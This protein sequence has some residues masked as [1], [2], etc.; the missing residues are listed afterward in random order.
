MESQEETFQHP[1]GIVNFALHSR[2]IHHVGIEND[3]HYQLFACRLISALWVIIAMSESPTGSPWNKKLR[4]LLPLAMLGVA[5]TILWVTYESHQRQKNNQQAKL[6]QHG[7]EELAAARAMVDTHDPHWRL[8]DFPKRMPSLAP[9]QDAA[10]FYQQ[11]EQE[12]R[13]KTEEMHKERQYM[14]S[15]PWILNSY[16][17]ERPSNLLPSETIKELKRTQ[18][19]LEKTL[20]F[21]RQAAKLTKGNFSIPDP[22]EVL[23]KLKVKRNNRMKL[24]FGYEWIKTQPEA[25]MVNSV[26]APVCG[27][28]V[29]DFAEEKPSAFDQLALALHLSMLPNQP[30]QD[31]LMFNSSGCSFCLLVLE[32]MMGQRV[33]N[34]QEL[35]RL[36]KQLEPLLTM[37]APLKNNL[38]FTRALADFFADAIHHDVAEARLDF[39][40]YPPSNNVINRSVAECLRFTTEAIDHLELPLADFHL[41]YSQEKARYPGDASYQG[42]TEFSRMS[43]E[44]L[45]RVYFL[46]Y[47]EESVQRYYNHQER[48]RLALI[49]LACERYRLHHGQFPG[50][51]EQLRTLIDDDTW[52]DLFTPSSPIQIQLFPTPT[53]L[54][55]SKFNHLIKTHDPREWEKQTSIVSDDSQNY[56]LGFRLYRPE[57]RGQ[58]SHQL[59]LMRVVSLVAEISFSIQRMIK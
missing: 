5:A 55:L 32:W 27:Q 53:G 8:K 39:W 16:Y 11:A 57:L 50:K 34:E 30:G 48:I 52:S 56:F 15:V 4:A 29:L 9:E 51:P 26:V 40:K 33:I 37:S 17:I 14:A 25:T 20:H 18:V 10:T 2:R 19:A 44:R 28:A 7:L 49:A 24:L 3:H 59:L 45:F 35:L 12:W 36:Q 6:E 13:Q 47:I 46:G 1:G 43:P 21:T 22:E 58:P 41:W 23:E 31:I 38:I 54:I 42:P